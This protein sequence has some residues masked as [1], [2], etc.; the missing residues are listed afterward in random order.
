MAPRWATFDCYGTLV[1]WH[2]GIQAELARIF[3]SS[4]AA[5]LLAR[6]HATEPR[7]Q[8]GISEAAPFWEA[9]AED[10]D[11]LQ[12]YPCGCTCHFPRPGWKLPH[13]ETMA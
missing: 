1:D 12:R 13:R 8:S 2:A 9:E 7:I 10:Q 3:G 11:Y 4:A 6:Y 5:G